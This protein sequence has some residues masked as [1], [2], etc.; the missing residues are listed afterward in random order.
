MTRI[1]GIAFLLWALPCAIALATPPVDQSPQLLDAEKTILED[2]EVAEY[3]E[4]AFADDV[5]ESTIVPRS[6][7]CKVIPGDSQW[8]T[9]ASWALFDTLAGGQLVKPDPIADVCYPGA[10]HNL[11]RCNIVSQSWTDSDLHLAHPNSIMNPLYQGL[12]CLPDDNSTSTCRQG[13]YP[14]YILDAKD[15]RNIQ[16]GVNFARN[17]NV[18]LVHSDTCITGIKLIENYGKNG[19]DGPAFRIGA[20]VIARDLYTETAKHNLVVVGGEGE[21]VGWGG[22]YIQGGG[23][24]PLGSVYGMAAD[25]VLSF[26][27]VLPSGRFVTADATQNTDVFWALRGGGGSTFG[28]VVSTTAKAYP[29]PP[30][31]SPDSASSPPPRRTQRQRRFWAV[32]RSYL[33]QLAIHADAGIYTYFTIFPI[34]GGNIMFTMTP[35]FAPNKTA[36]E[37]TTLLQPVLD[38]AAQVGVTIAP[39]TTTHDNFFDAWKIGFPKEAVGGYSAQPASRLFPRANWIDEAK[40]NATYAAIRT[41]V[42]RADTVGLIAFNIAPTLVRGGNADNAVNSHWRDNMLHAITFVKWDES[43]RDLATIRALQEEFSTNTMQAWRDVSPGAGSYLNEADINEPNWQDS[44]WGTKYD[45]LYEIK[46]KVDP[47]GLF[48][49]PT[50]VGSED[51]TA[52]GCCKVLTLVPMDEIDSKSVQLLPDIPEDILLIIFESAAYEDRRTAARSLLLVNKAVKHSLEKI[53]Y[54]VVILYNKNQACVF[55]RTLVSCPHLPPLVHALA[56]PDRCTAEYIEHI[57]ITCRSITAL[58]WYPKNSYIPDENLST[59]R[60]SIE[61]LPLKILYLRVSV[62]IDREHVVLAVNQGL[63]HLGMLNDWVEYVTL[64][65]QARVMDSR[66][67]E[68][69]THLAVQTPLPLTVFYRSPSWLRSILKSSKYLKTCIAYIEVDDD[70]EDYEDE[71]DALSKELDNERLVILRSRLGVEEWLNIVDG[72]ERSNAVIAERVVVKRRSNRDRSDS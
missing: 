67:F 16:L 35:F 12:T 20:G 52:G 22:G 47:W 61:S 21:T 71:I 69:L 41:Q 39:N 5:I 54:G 56:L 10:Q 18:R 1:R 60:S 32:V 33:S 45:R 38:T 37:V 53:V 70:G 43:V 17:K 2:A 24:S 55:S 27:V 65:R 28:V 4:F 3:P 30:S 11:T 58:Y 14:I 64:R 34:G 15:V 57:L 51:W 23:H 42:N 26:E 7:T 59:L 9:L 29:S 8:P 31:P 48:Y 68:H 72:A 46:Q 36:A 6:R 66:T 44:F 40:F 25:H 19:Y 49:A 62:F 50:A 13:G 63:T